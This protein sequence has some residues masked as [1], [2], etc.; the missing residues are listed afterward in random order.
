MTRAGPTLLLATAIPEGEQGRFEWDAQHN[1]SYLV[2]ANGGQTIEWA[3]DRGQAAWVPA[4]TLARLHS[5]SFR[6]DFVVEEMAE[7][8]IGIGFMLLW[9]VGPDWGFFGYL[10]SS[11]TAWSYDLSS[12]DVVCNTQSIEG[13]LPKSEDGHTGVVSV[14]LD[15]PRDAPG[16]AKFSVNGVD[17]KTIELPD[18]AVVLPAACLLRERQRVRLADFSQL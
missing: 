11:T 8:Q 16:S 4:Q 5:G 6:W 1:A 17:S 2:V 12:G 9:D 15:L 10:G 13:G 7:R 3:A 18:S 14:H